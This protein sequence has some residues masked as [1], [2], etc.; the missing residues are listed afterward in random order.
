MQ[1]EDYPNGVP[2]YDYP[3]DAYGNVIYPTDSD[4]SYDTGYYD[5]AYGNENPYGDAQD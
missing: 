5:N 3:T 2:Q 4:S 1:Y